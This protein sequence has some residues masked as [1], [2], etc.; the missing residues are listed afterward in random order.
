LP[1]LTHL[2]RHGHDAAAEATAG[3]L[4]ETQASLAALR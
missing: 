4:S 3:L 2:R 1:A